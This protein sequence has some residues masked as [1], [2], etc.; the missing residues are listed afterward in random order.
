MLTNGKMRVLLLLDNMISMALISTTLALLLWNYTPQ[1]IITVILALGL[2]VEDSLAISKADRSELED[3][4]QNI[5]FIPKKYR[6]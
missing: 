3:R 2:A 6:K 5:V 4:M 1:M